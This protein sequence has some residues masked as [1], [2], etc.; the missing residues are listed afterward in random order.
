MFDM[1]D[2]WRETTSVNTQG[3]S[4]YRMELGKLGMVQVSE[5]TWQYDKTQNPL[6]LQGVKGWNN[7]NPTELPM[8]PDTL[9]KP[10]FAKLVADLVGGEVVND[11]QAA[12]FQLNPPGTRMLAIKLGDVVA[13]AAAIGMVMGND[14]WKGN[15]R[16]KSV[17]IS[18]LLG[19]F[20]Q[21]LTLADKIW[22]AL[23]MGK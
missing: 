21:D 11:P 16:A 1:N 13:N 5:D 15:A 9:A 19:I 4:R 17:E 7:W 3:R 23:G 20:P 12:A 6:L 10:G 2:D 18:D 22:D 14:A 8:N